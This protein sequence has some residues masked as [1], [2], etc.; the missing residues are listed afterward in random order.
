MSAVYPDMYRHLRFGRFKS[1]VPIAGTPSANGAKVVAPFSL[2]F[3]KTG[4][5]FRLSTAT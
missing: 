3:F 4:G 1:D 5:I 2:Q